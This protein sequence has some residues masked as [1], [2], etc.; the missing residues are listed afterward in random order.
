MAILVSLFLSL[1]ANTNC[2]QRDLDRDSHKPC[3]DQDSDGYCNRDDF[4]PGYDD[5]GQLVI[6]TDDLDGYLIR[7]RGADGFFTNTLETDG[8]MLSD[9]A[10]IYD[11]D[12]DLA[13]MAL[14]LD[15]YRKI[16]WDMVE[17]V[18]LKVFLLNYDEFSIPGW[19]ACPTQSISVS[20]KMSS[21]LPALLASACNCTTAGNPTTCTPEYCSLGNSFDV[22]EPRITMVDLGDGWFELSGSVL[23]DSI[24]DA[25]ETQDY[26]VISLNSYCSGGYY[27]GWKPVEIED[28]GNHGNS[29]NLP[30]IEFFFSR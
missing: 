12:Y 28:S 10:D 9:Q 2:G 22:V 19:E 6:T 25:S 23:L 20:I 27:V 5:D 15:P 4:W 30:T 3:H 14:P 13:V 8:A 7:Q 1:M 29:G 11:M 24:R 26:L 17:D 18:S 16:A 21:D